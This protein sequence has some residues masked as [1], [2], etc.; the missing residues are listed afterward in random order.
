VLE[1]YAAKI[2]IS[3]QYHYDDLI[4]MVHKFNNECLSRLSFFHI[5]QKLR[6]NKRKINEEAEFDN[7]KISKP[8][9]PYITLV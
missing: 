8:A 5:I 1:I 3:N 4:K 2:T 9:T 6:T 7:C